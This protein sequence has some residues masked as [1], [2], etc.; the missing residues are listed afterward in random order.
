MV[1]YVGIDPST[2]TGFVALD[3][4][5]NV[6]RAKELTGVGNKDPKRMASL[7]GEVMQFVQPDDVICIEGF[8]FA[9]QQAIQLGGIGWGIRIA[10]WRRGLKYTEVA[11]DQVKKFVGVSSWTGEKGSKR[12]LSDKEKKAVVMA[13]V[14]ERFAFFHPNH[15][16]NDAYIMAQIARGLTPDIEMQ[17]TREQLEVLQAI[18][19][20]TEKKPKR[21]KVKQG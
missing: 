20:P 21:K 10:L 8:G 6:L 17:I 3:E 18:R 7:I 1:R 16:V 15:N 13:A 12:R 2:K 19:S 11:P 5:G 14:R 4:A 9:S